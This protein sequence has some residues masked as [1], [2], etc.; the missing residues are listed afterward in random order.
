M[1]KSIL[2][3]FLLE[4]VFTIVPCQTS[5]RG[6]AG[7]VYKY[8]FTGEP[9]FN[10]NNWTL[11]FCW[12]YDGESEGVTE[13]KYFLELYS[14]LELYGSMEI[15]IE[16]DEPICDNISL[17]FRSKDFCYIL[18]M[19]DVF[20]SLDQYLL[21]KYG[22]FLDG[23]VNYYYFFPCSAKIKG[24]TPTKFN[25]NGQNNILADSIE[26]FGVFMGKGGPLP[27]LSGN[28]GRFFITY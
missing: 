8:R 15:Y 18:D 7:D 6:Y 13:E 22:L 14:S 4:L 28:S 24:E 17:S 2:V 5:A 16:E 25:N 1:K 27:S 11:I 9:V 26:G 21:E 10:E 3:L 23:T 19:V 20:D 12:E